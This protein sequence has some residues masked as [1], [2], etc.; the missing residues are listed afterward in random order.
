[1]ARV[2]FFSDTHLD[3]ASGHHFT[4]GVN[5]RAM[6][7]Y[8]AFEETITQILEEGV[9]LVLHGGDLFHKSTPTVRGIVHARE[10]F[11]RLNA[12]GIPAFA[13]VGNHDHPNTTYRLPACMAVHDPEHGVIVIDGIGGTIPLAD[14]LVIHAVP[15]GGLMPLTADPTPQDGVVNILLTHGAVELPNARFDTA[16]SPA[17]AFIPPQMLQKDWSLML[18]G[19]F[20][21]RQA[22]PMHYP[23]WY[24]GSALRRG[25]SDEPGGR[26]WL[27]IDI[28]SDGT[29]TVTEKDIYQR[30]QFDFDVVDAGSLTGDEVYERIRAN[31]ESIDHAGFPIV[32]QKIVNITSGVRKTIPMDSLDTVNFLSWKPV[33]SRPEKVA[34]IN[35]ETGLVED[36]SR[37]IGSLP[38]LDAWSDF[39]AMLPVTDRD[40]EK[41]I[42]DGRALIDGAGSA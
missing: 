18:A 9:D 6:D 22:L 23:A 15:H 1:M 14:G 2:A 13:V 30:P 27:L 10:Q 21:Q 36:A 38:L 32:R 3:Y 19:H 28:A 31:I 16:D 11:A 17:E 5:T 29:C 42:A 34:A 37:H 4:D 40:R 25:F 12:A 24:A 35:P 7:G 33:F 8:V 20:H 26:G 39:A 41:V